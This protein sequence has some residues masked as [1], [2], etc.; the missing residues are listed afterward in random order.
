MVPAD[1]TS[2]TKSDGVKSERLHY[3]D[4]LQ[5][6]AVLG[7]FLFHAV[8]P[9]DDLADWHIKNVEKSV[10]ATFFVGFFNL[11]GMPFFFLMAGATSWFSLRRRTAGRYIN[12]RVTRLLIPFIIGAIVL[13]PIQAYFELTHK[14]WW[15][16]GSIIEF[17]LSSEARTYYYSVYHSLTLGPAI[18]GVVGYHLWFVAFLFA[19]ALIALPV[20]IWLNGDSGKRFVATLARLAK[21]R[22]G[23]LVFVIPLT[24]IRF[25]L[26]PFFPEYT[27]WSDFFFLLVF[28]ISG[29]M[30]ISDQRFIGAIQRDWWLHLILATACTLFFFSVAAGVPVGDWM[31]SPGTPGFY[32]SWTLH[33]INSWCWTM[34]F[35]YIGMRFLD[36]TGRWLQYSREASY[37]FFFF[38]QPAIIFIAFFAVQWEIGLSI[39]GLV[40]VIGAFV[41]TLATYELLVRRI[42]PVRA[43][44]GMKPRKEA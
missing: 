17:I 32:I 13:T 43:L 15:G 14:G 6:L 40:V 35:F 5:V 39:K 18:F 8:H 23:L 7:V 37:P 10:L 25:I 28:F 9:F 21:W 22:G 24:L 42:N 33:A 38:H 19:F 20:F 1:S 41:V 3:L 11:W 29:Y 27:G 34:V 12:G 4:W 2:N 30:L 44:F 16:G 31:W 26:Q 36:F